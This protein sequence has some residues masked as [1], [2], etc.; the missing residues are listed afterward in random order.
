MED[1]K[2]IGSED[3]SRMK[4]RQGNSDKHLLRLVVDSRMMNP[5]DDVKRHRKS[6]G[7]LVFNRSETKQTANKVTVAKAY[8]IIV[9]SWVCT[10]GLVSFYV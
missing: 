7:P 9:K 2:F 1:E 8:G 3:I 4:V 5:T 10:K 6:R